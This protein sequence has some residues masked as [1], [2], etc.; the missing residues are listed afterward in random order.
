[1]ARYLRSTN[2]RYLLS[3]NKHMDPTLHKFQIYFETEEIEELN[4]CVSVQGKELSANRLILSKYVKFTSTSMVN[5]VRLMSCSILITDG[6]I[7]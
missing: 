1:M 2:L 3:F 4:L 6:Y 7:I 5:S